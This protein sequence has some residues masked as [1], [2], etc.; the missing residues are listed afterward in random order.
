[1]FEYMDGIVDAV[2]EIGQAA[3]DVAVYCL[4]C[5]AKLALIITAPVWLLPY[6]IW[7]KG[8]KQ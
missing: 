8:R 5:V 4:I 2:E 7:R 3:V 6:T 1:M